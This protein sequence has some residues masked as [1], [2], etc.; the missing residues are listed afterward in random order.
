VYL[1]ARLLGKVGG[2]FVATRSLARQHPVPPLIGLGLA[3][4]GG[5]GLAIVIEYRFAVDDPLVPLVFGI[6]MSALLV[7]ELAAPWLVRRVVAAADGGS[8]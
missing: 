2:G 5:M 7:N 3:S 1:G 6:A 8:P 4:Q